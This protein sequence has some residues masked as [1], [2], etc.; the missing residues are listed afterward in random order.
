MRLLARPAVL[1]ALAVCLLHNTNSTMAGGLASNEHFVVLAT[2]QALADA[3]LAKAT[4]LGQQL[5]RDWL[6]KPLPSNL[7]RRPCIHA[8]LS[9]SEDQG[10]TW[11]D[12]AN[13]RQYGM[14]WVTSSRERLLGSTL[15][16]EVC[17]LVLAYGCQGEGELPAWATE[18]A[19]SLQDNRELVE[20]RERTL[21][22][23]AQNDRWPS[24]YSILEKPSIGVTDHSSYCIATSLTEY[25]LSCGDKSRVVRFALAGKQKGWD[26]A[27]VEHYKLQNVQELQNAWQTWANRRVRTAERET[28]IRSDLSTGT[29]KRRS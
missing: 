1:I 28:P 25:L 6:G 26:Q 7:I 9:D 22:S 4:A 21:R 10:T 20:I 15:A 13:G 19:A 16:H 5:S 14:V 3:V 24:L 11:I 18:G 23:F 12:L 8:T 2:D 17:H 27:V 29:T